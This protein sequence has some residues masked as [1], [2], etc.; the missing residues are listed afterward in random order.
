MLFCFAFL[1]WLRIAA[2]QP[3]EILLLR[4]LCLVCTTFFKLGYLEFWCLIT[5]LFIYFEDLSSVSCGH[6]D[7]LFLFS[8]LCF[9][10]FLTVSTSFTKASQLPEVL[11]FIVTLSV[12]ATGVIFR[13]GSLLLMHWRLPPTFSSI[14]LRVAGFILYLI[15]LNLSFVHGDTY[16]SLCIPLHADIQLWQHHL[17]KILYSIV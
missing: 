10:F 16:W 1:W 8:S 13:K 12:C 2:L 17:L 11:I 14:R 6:G 7:D 15:H 4:I 5:W 3:L 9:F